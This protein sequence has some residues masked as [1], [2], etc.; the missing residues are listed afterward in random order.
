VKNPVRRMAD[1]H[2]RVEGPWPF[3]TRYSFEQEGRRIVRLARQHRKGLARPAS[4]DDDR[5]FWHLPGYNWSMGAIFALGSL[6]FMVGSVFSLLP[7]DAA[8][9]LT[10]INVVFL[11]GSI[12]FT[13]AAYL[14][15]FQAANVGSLVSR[16]R[17][18][19]RRAKIALIGWDPGS[20]GWLSTFTQ[21]IGTLAFNISTL[22]AI[23]VAGGWQT[24]DVAVWA[25]DMIGSF[26]FLV[27]GYLAF[28][29]ASHRYWSWKPAELDWQIV[30]VNLIGCIAFMTAG[31]LSYVPR[32]T[33]ATWVP[34]VS[35]IHLL[36]GATCFFIGSL[37]TM[38]ESQSA[39]SAVGEVKSA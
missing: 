24:Q 15:H 28:I 23:V 2:G 14:Q 9:P 36:L 33:E 7:R 6:L 4:G 13:I 31:I 20:P 8:P 16:S 3:I 5:P 1:R 17:T 34:D 38:R 39:R 19:P 25:P 37:L 26:M 21:F 29:E 12:P 35:N 27:S 10:V 32:H 18:G 22:D 11:L 30:F